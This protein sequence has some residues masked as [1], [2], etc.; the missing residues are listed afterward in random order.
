[1]PG[2]H[3]NDERP[4]RNSTSRRENFCVWEFLSSGRGFF[5]IR[6]SIVVIQDGLIS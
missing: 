3:Y 6:P 2:L 5:A 1:M 4:E